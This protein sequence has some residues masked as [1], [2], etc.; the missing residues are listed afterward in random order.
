VTAA[1]TSTPTLM[2]ALERS[3]VDAATLA[4]VAALIELAS[5]LDGAATAA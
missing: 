3:E 4:Q 2:S 1:Q 5:A